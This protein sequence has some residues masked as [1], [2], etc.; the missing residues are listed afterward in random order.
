MSAAPV[1]AATGALLTPA[2]AIAAVRNASIPTTA[3]GFISMVERQ[4]A[5]DFAAASGGI[6]GMWRYYGEN[7]ARDIARIRALHRTYPPNKPRGCIFILGMP[8]HCGQ[9]EHR[10]RR[11]VG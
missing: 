3:K 7:T 11:A 10:H 6:E 4:G 2:A 1:S 5:P 8:T 9:A